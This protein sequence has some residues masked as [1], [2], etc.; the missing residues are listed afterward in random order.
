MQNWKS[1]SFMRYIN[2][3]KRAGHSGATHLHVPLSGT[4]ETHAHRAFTLIELLVVIAIITILAG[5]LLP[6][7]GKVR[8]KAWM[9]KCFS[10]LHQIGIGMKIYVNDNNYT[11]PPAETRQMDPAA[12]TSYNYGNSIG[13]GD[14][15]IDYRTNGSGV[16]LAKDR[17]LYSI[18]SSGDTWKCPADRGIHWFRPTAFETTGCSYRF[19]HFLQDKYMSLN[20]AEDPLYNLALKKE[21]WPPNPSSF[22]TMHEYAA[23]PWDGFPDPKAHIT[24]WHEAS[25]PGKMYDA[26]NLRSSPDKFLSPVLFADG[27]VQR[28]DF[29][30]NIKRSPALALEPGKNWVWYRRVK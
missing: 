29:T 25:N 26:S 3:V 7:L 11:Y 24:S 20:V 15:S 21:N 1:R 14:P 17:P 9:T 12:A 5:M 22:I 10:N 23:F 8:Q 2:A 13:G 28:C 6:V 19:N 18:V 4:R 27:N 30:E 16:P